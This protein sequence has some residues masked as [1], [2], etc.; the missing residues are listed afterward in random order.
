MH[1]A[2]QIPLW[3]V[4][5]LLGLQLV[6]QLLVNLQWHQIAKFGNVPLS[7]RDMFFINCQGA[8]MDS[9]TPGVKIGGEITR[10]VQISRTAHCPG[11]QAAAVVAMQKVFS[12]GAFFL[13]NAFALGYIIGRTPFLEAQALRFFVYGIMVLFLLLFSCL[14]F[15]PGRIKAYVLAKEKPRSPWRLTLRRF[16]LTLLEQI[17]SI[18][19]NTKT[20]AMLFLLSALIW[21]LYPVKMYLLAMHLF[22][23]ANAVF[24]GAAAFVS[25][26][27]A[28][29]PIFPG[30][31]GGFEGTM[32]GLLLAM[33][34]MQSDALVLT[35]VFRFGTFWF[36][37]LFSILFIGFY[38]IRYIN[39]DKKISRKV[40][41]KWPVCLSR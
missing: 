16:L 17:I 32:S 34:F 13:I 5:L 38:R 15:M 36:V 23:G 7:F 21:L 33:G 1:S 6:S 2:R 19:K 24:I 9:I 37:M 14:F 10:S 31:L 18:R 3:S 4:A 27:V 35:V 22:P 12:L 41:T 30:G 28:M 29:I 39:V 11:E 25:Y 26:M 8:V 20:C 40:E